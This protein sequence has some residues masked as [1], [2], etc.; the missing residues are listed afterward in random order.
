[1]VM[2][3]FVSRYINVSIKQKS[4]KALYNLTSLIE[5]FISYMSMHA[6][7]CS[8]YWRRELVLRIH[9][10]HNIKSNIHK[11]H[12]QD[13][14]IAEW[15]TFCSQN[16]NEQVHSS[17]FQQYIMF[18]VIKINFKILFS[19]FYTENKETVQVKMSLF[20]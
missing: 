5:S 10:D 18:A 11:P 4:A 14:L 13:S 15:L 9:V 19:Y 20:L 3:I 1:M 17:T 7:A 16:L 6:T 8:K 12:S 2:Y